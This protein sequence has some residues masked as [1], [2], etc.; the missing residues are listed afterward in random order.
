H[1]LNHRSLDCTMSIFVAQTRA[2]KTTCRST[3]TVHVEKR[4]LPTFIFVAAFALYFVTRGIGLDDWDSA[5]VAMGTRQFDLWRHQP[6]P[7]GYP[8][9]ILL[10]V[11]LDNVFHFGPE[12]SLHLISC[13]GGAL[14]V[15]TWFLIT[16]V[17]FGQSSAWL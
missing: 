9:F 14:F 17:Y 15:A 1:W 3:T 10:A 7:P 5:Q 11:T 2:S 13:L 16:R 12:F 4:C 8:L 6:H